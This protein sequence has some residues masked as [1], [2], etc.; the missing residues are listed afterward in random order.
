MI[1]LTQTNLLYAPQFYP[2]SNGKPMA[3]NTQQYSWIVI[4]K[5]NLEILCKGVPLVFIAADLL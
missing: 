2:E 5:E 3:E 1:A 4:L